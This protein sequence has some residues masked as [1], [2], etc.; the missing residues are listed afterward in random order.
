[1]RIFDGDCGI[2]IGIAVEVDIE[3]DIAIDVILWNGLPLKRLTSV[4]SLRR[5]PAKSAPFLARARCRLSA[6]L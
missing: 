6:R 2:G 1:M 3:L 5:R 4:M